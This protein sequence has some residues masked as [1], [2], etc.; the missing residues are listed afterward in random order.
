MIACWIIFTIINPA[1]IFA[2]SMNGPHYMGIMTSNNGRY[3][4]GLFSTYI[5]FWDLD[6]LWEP[7]QPVQVHVLRNFRLP[8]AVSENGKFFLYY[9]N[10]V[11]RMCNMDIG[12]P[13][14][15]LPSFKST[16]ISLQISPEGDQIAVLT[17]KELALIEVNTNGSILKKKSHSWPIRRCL[18]FDNAEGHTK[19]TNLDHECLEVDWDRLQIAVGTDDGMVIIIDGTADWKETHHLDVAENNRGTG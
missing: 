11:I 12:F 16:P 18:E 14:N 9:E 17:Y 4:M 5:T 2:E 13:C 10:R 15:N 19:Y 1:V 6:R 3:V 8:V 7:I